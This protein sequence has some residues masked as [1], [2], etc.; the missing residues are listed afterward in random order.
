MNSCYV[1]L[2]IGLALTFPP[3]VIFDEST[4]GLLLQTRPSQSMADHLSPKKK[5][6]SSSR[7]DPRG[8]NL[9]A[10]G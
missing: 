8:Y 4:E 2:T 10:I 1:V 3:L 6:P 9:M 7:I 5:S